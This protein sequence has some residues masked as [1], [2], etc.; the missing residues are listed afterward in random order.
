MASSFQV[1]FDL[2]PVFDVQQFNSIIG[3][4]KDSLGA[5]GQTLKPI[6]A[7]R[8]SA[9]LE[10][11]RGNIKNTAQTFQT[12]SIKAG[13]SSKEAGEK[14]KNISDAIKSSFKP[15]LDFFGGGLLLQG[16]SG[17]TGGLR[18]IYEA[19]KKDL[20]NFEQMS[21]VFAQAGVAAEKLKDTIGETNKF[22][23]ELAQKFAIPT[24][25]IRHFSRIAAGIGG[26]TGQANR[27]LSLLA[28][29]VEKVSEGLVS[30]E[31]AIRIFSKGVSDPE[32]QFALG[33]LTK[34]FPAL[35]AALKDVQSP[36]EATQKALSFFAPALQQ[37][38]EVST[39]AVGSVVKFQNA[40]SQIRTAMGKILIEAASPFITAFSEY[41]MPVFR[42]IV[43]GITSVLNTTKLLQPVFVSAGLAAAGLV[44]SLLALQSIKVFAGL[45]TSA[46]QFGLSIL[47]KVVP[48]LV[49]ENTLT[50]TLVLQKNALTV[51]TVKESIANLAN[52]STRAVLTGATS[53]L[54]SAQTALNGAFLASPVGWVV[55]GVGALVAGMVALY[56]NVE[57]VRNL[58]NAA[59]EIIATGAKYTWEI[60]KKLGEILWEIGKITF[61]FVIAPFQLVWEMIKGIGTAI[62]NFVASIL[63]LSDSSETLSKILNALG[64]AFDFVMGGLNSVLSVVKAVSAAISS[65]VGG[66]GSAIVKLLQGDIAGFITALGSAG[67]EAGQNFTDK[68]NEELNQSNFEEAAGKLRDTIEKNTRIQLQI[69]QKAT[70]DNLVKGY[71]DIQKQ[72]QNL[73]AKSQTTGLTEEEQRKL[74]ELKRKALE[75]SNSIA[76]ILPET[77]TRMQTIVDDTGKIQTVWEV[78]IEKAKEYTNAAKQQQELQATT[79]SYA[80]A[81]Q[82]QAD[83]LQA[84]K[85][86][87]DDLKQRIQ[88]TNDPAQVEKLT[89]RYNELSAAYDTNKQAMVDAFVEGSKAG[90]MTQE[91]LNAIAQALSIT[92]DEAKKI[93]IAKELEE[94]N[95]QGKATP[96]LV[97]K[98]AQ[99]YMVSQE[100]VRNLLESQRKI[101]SEIKESEMAAKSLA[102]ALSIAK[103][104]QEEG[105]GQ[106]IKAIA[107]LKS[108]RITQEE[109]NIRLDEGLKKIKDGARLQKEL[110][111]ATQES[112]KLG[113]DA[114]LVKDETVAK[115]KATTTEK[116]TQL[117]LE[118]ELYEM[119]KKG[120]DEN[121]KSFELQIERQ[122]LLAGKLERSSNDELKI[123]DFKMAKH[124]EQ[125]DTLFSLVNKYKIKVDEFGKI[126]FV[127]R[128]KEDEAE[129]I[130]QEFQ[131]IK[132]TLEED[133]NNK[134]KISIK[135]EQEKEKL[136]LETQK[137]QE[138]FDNLKLSQ[139]EFQAKIGI[140]AES[141]LTMLKLEKIKSRIEALQQELE[142]SSTIDVSTDPAAFNKY[143]QTLLEIQRL[144]LDLAKETNELN[145]QL[146]EERLALVFDEAEKEKIITIEKAKATYEK[147]L[148]L[149]KDNAQLRAQAALKYFATVEKAEAEYLEKSQ[150]L[151]DAFQRSVIS[152]FETFADTITQYATSPIEE[153]IKALQE[154]LQQL[155][156]NKTNKEID[157]IRNE[158]RELIISLYRRE[159]SVAEYYQKT[160][161]LDRK[162]TQ[163][164]AQNASYVAQVFLKT[165]LGLVKSLQTMTQQWNAYAETNLKKIIENQQ[166]ISNLQQE[167]EKVGQA[168]EEQTKLMG[169]LQKK[170]TEDFSNFVV[171]A[172]AASLS[173][174]SSM[175]ASGASFAEAFRKGLLANI[176]DIAEKSILANI[177][178]IYSTFFAQL[179]LLG[180]PAAI[181]AIA[182]VTSAL[183]LA[184]AALSA[185]QGAVDIQGPGTETSD[186]IPARLSRGESVLSAG[187][188]R[189]KGNKELFLW[190]NKT[191][192]P[193]IEFFVTQ[194]PE[195]AQK[196]IS[197]Y[198]QTEKETISKQKEILIEKIVIDNIDNAKKLQEIA[199]NVK[200]GFQN[201][202][203]IIQSSGYVRKTINEIN[204]DVEFNAKEIINKVQIE[205]E[206]SLK[207]M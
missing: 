48:A 80:Q 163:L 124:K 151:K 84:Q 95:R 144:N 119:Q 11:I 36:A 167:I 44:T 67:Q 53:L 120:N 155:S 27:D 76:N 60:V 30:G 110:N 28:L 90:M 88:Q 178:V 86:H 77:R 58:F 32:S 171:G 202:A 164:Q 6:D 129:K 187:A 143:Q 59:W 73:V 145:R 22:A 149:A 136:K 79:N 7:G 52:A 3:S 150:K 61:Q 195:I 5:L 49:A 188:T 40:V 115:E 98:I 19:G 107:D 166:A 10:N 55:V 104:N 199:E 37:L 112:K 133:E 127:G 128:I 17:L 174:F 106:I 43:Q 153:K 198:F 93:P 175:L 173:A 113:I 185:Y 207:R 92:N 204:V 118:L 68:L 12:I 192:R 172:S 72:I 165:Q 39:G 64:Q 103:Q 203:Q 8:L 74:E 94:A 41:L 168:T 114:L 176:L 66:I 100:V 134:L 142:V 132:Q 83:V 70:T 201:L 71:E 99:K 85:Q 46:T 33:R 156:G 158:E 54:T 126:R 1:S 34:Q 200:N 177:P 179:G 191:K 45:A 182:I 123:L 154:R 189:A 111:A 162:R 21:V 141:D 89:K 65:F 205:K 109:Y 56:K 101:T 14:L 116:K 91:S 18:N 138:E 135:I 159:I 139:L 26:A 170:L 181:A 108:G 69:D 193:A 121:L 196:L 183:E 206:S 63:G 9:S 131:N 35:A 125:Y 105:R 190:L 25:E 169:E 24:S 29:A 117:L 50:G 13:E 78:N 140:A 186:S 42:G 15:M 82:K 23:F 184:K 160:N 4:I 157:N 122:N 16:F 147:E 102:D 96:E 31:M 180:M 51:A 146:R 97:E 161:E 130:F 2:V 137:I 87:L 152:S 148:L 57:S 47:Q 38:E 194:K 197:N 81:L 20:E 62:G 75:A